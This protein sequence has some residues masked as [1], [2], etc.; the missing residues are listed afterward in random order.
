MGERGIGISWEKR[1]EIREMRRQGVALRTIAKQCGVAY[2]TVRAN[3]ADI[4]VVVNP[5]ITEEMTAGIREMRKN[6]I[7]IEKIAKE[8]KISC[9]AVRDRCKDIVIKPDKSQ[10]TAEIV[11]K[12]QQMWAEGYSY[13]Q[14]ENE[15]DVTARTIRDHTRGIPH[16]PREHRGHYIP[17]DKIERCRQLRAQGLTYHEIGEVVGISE[18]T[19]KKYTHDVP[20]TGSRPEKKK[21]PGNLCR[22]RKTCMYWKPM[23][24]MDCY[25]CHYNIDRPDNRPYPAD[26]CPGFPKKRVKQ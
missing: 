10:I 11:K 8:Y 14:I 17:A 23:S 20:V 19:V 2:E 15:L 22:H 25:A 26:E 6:G 4:S 9:T 13:T 1:E 12:I 5:K 21:E 16:K 18:S 7:S 24:G 3:T